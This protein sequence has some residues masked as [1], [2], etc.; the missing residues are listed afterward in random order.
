M[1]E[2][3]PRELDVILRSDRVRIPFPPAESRLLRTA[4][5]TVHQIASRVPGQ[6]RGECSIGDPVNGHRNCF[7]PAAAQPAGLGELR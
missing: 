2:L 1:S 3:S 7:N 6:V 4:K 5:V